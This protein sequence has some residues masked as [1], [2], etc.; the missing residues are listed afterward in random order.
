[1]ISKNQIK[2][3]KSLKQKKFRVSNKC[4]VVEGNKN[5]LE[6]INSNYEILNLFA[7]K[8][9]LES[10]KIKYVFPVHQIKEQDLQRITSLNSSPMVLAVVKIPITQNINNFLGVNI[11]FDNISDPGNLGTII[12]ICDWF[13]I[14]NIYLSENSVDAYNPK[15]VQS[16][17]G[18]ISR[19]NII[20]TELDQLINDVPKDV[21]IY[22]AV[23]NGEKLND[24]LIGKNSLIFF[25]NESNGISIDLLNKIQ[26]KITIPR[27]GNADSLNV[28]VSSGIILNK[29]CT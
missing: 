4:F 22:A 18:S 27:I 5:V 19:V 11:A 7:I 12:R 23:M 21:D 20:Y 8:N 2:F 25:G 29:F 6:I 14:K 17:M 1:M 16:T 15:V 10:N 24:I 9:W 3:I 28:S 26:T 13:G